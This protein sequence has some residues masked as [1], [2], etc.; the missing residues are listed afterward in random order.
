MRSQAGKVQIRSQDSVSVDGFG[1]WR[2][3]N[4]ITLFDSQQQYGDNALL[5]GTDTSGT[6][7]VA[8]RLTEASVRLSTGGTASGAYAYRESRTHFRYQPG[9]CQLAESTYVMSAPQ[10]GTRQRIGLFDSYNGMFLQQTVA[11]LSLV[12]RSSTS[13]VP[14]DISVA[15]DDWSEDKFDGQGPS[16]LVLETLAGQI[17]WFDFQWLG[18][19]RVR[20]GFNIDG[21]P[22][23]AHEFK[24]ANVSSLV[25]MTSANLPFR[26]EVQ[27]TAAAGGIVYLDQ[28]CCSIQSEGG[29]E[30]ERGLPF[31]ANTGSGL[32]AVT[33]RRPLL[34][35]RAKLLGPNG[36]INTGQIM[37]ESGKVLAEDASCLV[38]LVRNA[39]LT[40]ASWTNVNASHSLAESDIS[41]TAV[42][43]GH[44]IE[45]FG[46]GAG[47]LGSAS[48][49]GSGSTSE[50]SRLP[51]VR[52]GLGTPQQDTLTV[53]ATS[54][55]GTCNALA[56]VN[57]KELY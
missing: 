46:V 37:P 34:S 3:S 6:G 56:A 54:T 26:A 52:A 10:T 39:T 27:N 24:H 12:L 15:R 49:P 35:V 29:F 8:N 14:V 17:L 21:V 28:V 33:T 30:A 25:Y 9:K 45:S 42:S 36:V 43:G 38:E 4:P 44:V 7:S 11:G 20:C 1:R 13:G 32:V 18:L 51:L 23:I 31:T 2:V 41:A 50:F 22:H 16:G 47:S 55:S 5:W 57:W 40:G 53:V 19:G 48:I